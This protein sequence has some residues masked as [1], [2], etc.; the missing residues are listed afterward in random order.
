MQALVVGKAFLDAQR[1]YHLAN[2]KFA[3]D[4]DSLDIT[5]PYMPSWQFTG[6]HSDGHGQLIY[7]YPSYDLTWDFYPGT[8]T[9]TLVCIVRDNASNT[10]LLKETCQ[11][12]TGKDTP[13]GTDS[14]LGGR[15]F[16]YLR[17]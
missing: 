1:A 3:T 12:L 9:H 6:P 4:R 13:S 17:Y 15:T 16:Y 14:Q 7:N 11:S 10:K 2:G 5:I 8:T